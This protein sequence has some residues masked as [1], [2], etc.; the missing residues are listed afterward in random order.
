M[1]MIEE[2]SVVQRAIERAGAMRLDQVTEGTHNFVSL[3]MSATTQGKKVG[4]VMHKFP[5]GLDNP[6][7]M[8]LLDMA[9]LMEAMSRELAEMKPPKSPLIILKD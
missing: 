2:K 9:V 8:G 7:V 5:S 6:V 3:A 1:S 4:E